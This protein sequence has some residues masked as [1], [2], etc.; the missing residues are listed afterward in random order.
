MSANSS[1]SEVFLTD[2]TLVSQDGQ[3]QDNS[4]GSETSSSDFVTLETE[5]GAVGYHKKDDVKGA[6]RVDEEQQ[7]ETFESGR[8]RDINKD[9]G[10][11]QE[12]RTEGDATT[13]AIKAEIKYF[14][15]PTEES[16]RREVI[17]VKLVDEGVETEPEVLVVLEDKDEN[18]TENKEDTTCRLDVVDAKMEDEVVEPEPEIL[19]MEK[20]DEDSDDK[21]EPE[22]R[23]VEELTDMMMADNEMSDDSDDNKDDTQHFQKKEQDD[24]LYENNAAAPL[25]PISVVPKY[26]RQDS[27][28]SSDSDYVRID[29]PNNIQCEELGACAACHS[30]ILTASTGT[31]ASAV[32]SLSNFCFL[33]RKA[34]KEGGDDPCDRPDSPDS[35]DDIDDGSDYESDVS[36][37]D[38]YSTQS[39]DIVT[40]PGVRRYRHYRDD[41]LNSKLNWVLVL[42]VTAGIALGIGHFIGSSNESHSKKRVQEG[43]ILRL[44]SLQNEL[45]TCLEKDE[46]QEYDYEL[47]SFML[48]PFPGF[49]NSITLK[50]SDGDGM[51]TTQDDEQTWRGS[52]MTESLDSEPDDVLIDDDSETNIGDTLN[53]ETDYYVDS[54]SVPYVIEQFRN[55]IH[56]DTL[57]DNLI[58]DDIADIDNFEDDIDQNIKQQEIQEDTTVSQTDTRLLEVPVSCPSRDNVGVQSDQIYQPNFSTDEMTK[59]VD[60]ELLDTIPEIIDDITV[61]DSMSDEVVLSDEEIGEEELV[62][63]I[64]PNINGLYS[65]EDSGVEATEVNID[66]VGSESHILNEDQMTAK[67]TPDVDQPSITPEILSC[68]Q[69]VQELEKD[70]SFAHGRAEMWK[71]LFVNEH[72][73]K[74]NGENSDDPALS[75]FTCISMFLPTVD[76]NDAMK[77]LHETPLANFTETVS[78]YYN[79]SGDVF[80]NLTDSLRDQWKKVND[81]VQS[82][83]FT[84]YVDASKEAVL[85]LNEMLKEQLEQIQN[86]SQSEQFEEISN[87]TK[88]AWYSVSNTLTQTWQQLKN[89]TTSDDFKSKVTKVGK[90]IQKT[91]QSVQNYSS[92]ILHGEDTSSTLESVTDTLKKTMDS[93]WKGVKNT[94]EHVMKKGNRNKDTPHHHGD[95]ADKDG[96]FKKRKKRWISNIRLPGEARRESHTEKMYNKETGEYRFKETRKNWLK[97]VK[98]SREDGPGFVNG[99]FKHGKHHQR[100]WLKKIKLPGEERDG[101]SWYD[102]W[103]DFYADN[104]D[105]VFEEA[106]NGGKF[107]FREPEPEPKATETERKKTNRQDESKD[108]TT[109][110]KNGRKQERIRN[111]INKCGHD[112]DDECDIQCHGNKHCLTKQLED[113]R[114]LYVE[115]LH[116]RQWLKVHRY[117]KDVKELEEFLDD[118]E[119]FMDDPHPD[120]NDL[121]E[122]QEDFEEVLE[123]MEKRAKKHNRRQQ[124]EK[125]QQEKE[126]EEI[127][128]KSDKELKKES[129][130]EEKEVK[131][132]KK[133]GTGQKK[134]GDHGNHARTKRREFNQEKVYKAAENDALYTYNQEKQTYS[135]V[136]NTDADWF[137]KRAEDREEQRHHIPQWENDFDPIDDWFFSRAQDRQDQRMG[138][139]M[140]DMYRWFAERYEKRAEWRKYD[141]DDQS[142]WFLR[143][144]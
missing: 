75:F 104:D 113:A 81:F 94:V 127:R 120:D 32:S 89:Y 34:V 76:I 12:K 52:T 98:Q 91:W 7:Q 138:V 72:S 82:E 109:N 37:L 111:D 116:Y 40:K 66:P 140:W 59:A 114:K 110:Q 23:E 78:E 27:C 85:T 86:M 143:R 139:T 11:M 1:D 107:D 133:Q 92:K 132:E 29:P 63:S 93:T 101:D 112:F 43:Q 5:D 10:P 30:D 19:V 95:S 87:K 125:E 28:S 51:E 36:I 56:V 55:P 38:N 58:D 128:Q 136:Q 124:K 42:V 45:L 64:E 31:N 25:I 22:D 44:K 35:I 46:I 121:E 131:D 26:L 99:K 62:H 6:V 9:G 3:I 137:F 73:S 2:W 77:T 126:L 88:S 90:S 21:S 134:K 50:I 119:D 60:T 16:P 24:E 96:K 53:D 68:Q 20:E 74:D 102:F 67:D 71:R 122:L 18:I 105:G 144:P 49:E 141:M 4:S 13:N 83:E 115:L 39:G 130:E 17:E 65:M 118:L 8:C 129:M 54:S 97:Q 84:S 41:G 15:M 135:T 100:K 57:E 142:N 69:R 61:S 70:L 108:K 14:E 33:P 48:D 106:E 79:S 80:H 117:K 103:K 47:D 123:D